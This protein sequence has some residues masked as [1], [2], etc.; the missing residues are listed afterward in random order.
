[1]QSVALG[2]L[3]ELRFRQDFPVQIAQ[4]RIAMGGA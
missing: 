3:E 2:P 1:M 4:R